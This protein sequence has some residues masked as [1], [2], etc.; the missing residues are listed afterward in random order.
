MRRGGGERRSVAG[1]EW[2]VDRT[3]GDEVNEHIPWRGQG[4]RAGDEAHKYTLV[5]GRS[6]CNEEGRAGG[7]GR[8]ETT[9]VD[10]TRETSF[11]FPFPHGIY[12][13]SSCIFRV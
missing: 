10:Y 4:G 7:G 6:T 13:V 1:Q 2:K 11:V 8:R 3:G 5:L 12:K 9:V